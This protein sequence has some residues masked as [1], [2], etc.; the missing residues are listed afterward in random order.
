MGEY[1]EKA[2][3]WA[4]NIA[5]DNTH[6]Y[7]QSVRWG[8]SYDCSSLVISA[9]EQA[10]APVKTKGAT[11]TGNMR[12]V[13]LS[14]GFKDVTSEI[15]LA[16]GAG[17][18]RGDVLLNIVN[19]TALYIGGG[20]LVHA[21]SSEGSTDTKDGSGNEIRTQAY[22]NYPWDCVL[23]YAEGEETQS[24]TGKTAPDDPTEEKYTLEFRVLARGMIGEDIRS[25]QR[26]LKEAGFDIGRYGADGE[27][28]YD[29]QNAVKAYQRSKG[30]DTD[31]EAGPKTMSRLYGLV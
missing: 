6:G 25:M 23:R 27:F 13:F 2:V 1:A 5:S 30:I 15:N 19:H 11:Y 26:L 24:G 20:Q 8:P 22:Y 7:S 10:G 21:R 9:F 29:T 17:L 4:L 31:G 14:C 28:G 3:Q 16:S 18:Q 12:P